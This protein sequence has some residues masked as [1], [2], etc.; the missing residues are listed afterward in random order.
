MRKLNRLIQTF[1]QS[2]SEKTKNGEVSNKIGTP[3]TSSQVSLPQAILLVHR[4]TFGLYVIEG[5]LRKSSQEKLLLRWMRVL[6]VAPSST[7]TQPEYSDQ[8]INS[9]NN[10]LTHHTV[11]GC[12]VSSKNCCLHFTVLGSWQKAFA[13]PFV[14]SAATQ[15]SG[16]SHFFGGLLKSNLEQKMLLFV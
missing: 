11:T 14:L 12:W 7:L 15:K 8:T 16:T 10:H 5:R 6:A 13:F 1:H 2:W 9:H 3:T 4:T